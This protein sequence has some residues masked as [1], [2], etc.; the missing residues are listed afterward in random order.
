MRG[1]PRRRWARK[2]P[3]GSE[4]G[5]V[6]IE[7]AL[8]FPLLLG[9]M[10]GIM[11]LSHYGFIQISI[12]N[13]AHDG[14]R[15]AV[16]HSSISSTP[17]G[18]SDISTYVTNELTGYGLTASATITVTYNTSNAPG[19]TVEVQISYPFTPFMPGFN[20]IPGIPGTFTD[21]VGP[22]KAVSEMVISE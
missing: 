3:I 11:E 14:V 5:H 21:V 1:R 17:L 6:A 2:P 10:Y 12:S 20:Q 13:A 18:S 4:A 16:V 7:Y 8:T 9:L 22:I 19:N 15:Y